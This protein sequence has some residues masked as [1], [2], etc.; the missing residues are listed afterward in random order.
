[1][2]RLKAIKAEI[3]ANG[4]IPFTVA[5]VGDDVVI[6]ARMPAHR[7]DEICADGAHFEDWEDDGHTEAEQTTDGYS[8]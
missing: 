8:A 4:E 6:I 3:I 5:N 7:F 1:M 2:A